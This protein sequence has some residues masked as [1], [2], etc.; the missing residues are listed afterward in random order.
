MMFV[1]A[2][3]RK[4]GKI[5]LLTF[6]RP[7]YWKASEILVKLMKEDISCDIVLI[8]GSFHTL[9][10]FLGSIGNLMTWTGLQPLLEQVYAE[11]K[12]SAYIIW[13]SHG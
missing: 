4:H 10:S 9:M 12:R 11:N 3:A 13:E 7:L 1:D 2:Q 5:P 8:L 6:D